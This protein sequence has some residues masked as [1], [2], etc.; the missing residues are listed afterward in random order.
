LRVESLVA[1]PTYFETLGVSLLRGRAFD[2]SDREDAAPVAIVNETMARR[3]LG[4]VDAL[5][6]HFRYEAE[7]AAP[8]TIV[9][10]VSDVRT[11]VMEAPEPLLYRPFRQVSSTTPTV[12]VRTSLETSSVVGSM[13]SVVREVDPALPV[14]MAKTMGRHLDDSLLSI[15]VAAVALAAL[16]LAGLALACVGLHAVV[17]FAVSRRS[18]E[19]GIRMALGARGGQVVRLVARQVAGLVG[20]GVAVGLGLSWLAIRAMSATAADLSASPHIEVA[21]P[22]VDPLT[23]VLVALAIGAAGVAATFAPAR[24]ASRT[25]PVVALRHQ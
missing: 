20:A 2:E 25:D 21:G 15:K 22:R 8:V 7:P 23:F 18:R 5:G 9:G 17:A 19:L 13:L 3:F 4:T 24:R 6:R 11:E 10:V 1:G 12:L 14:V 16:G